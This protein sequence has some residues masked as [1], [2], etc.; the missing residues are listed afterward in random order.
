[1]AL[2]GKNKNDNGEESEMD[3]KTNPN[4][5]QN[6][7]IA[8]QTKIGE[9]KVFKHGETIG[10]SLFRNRIEFPK[11]AADEIIEAVRGLK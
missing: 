8:I 6:N 11:D 9:Y 7:V 3:I 10:I 1:M 5:A 2:Y 4:P